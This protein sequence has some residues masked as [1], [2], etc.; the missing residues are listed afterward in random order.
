MREK[1][2]STTALEFMLDQAIHHRTGTVAL[3]PAVHLILF[4]LVQGKL[5]LL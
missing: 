3:I 1:T 2:K 4:F 5:T